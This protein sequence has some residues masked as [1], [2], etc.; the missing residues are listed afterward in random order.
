[1]RSRRT[2]GRTVAILCALALILAA[3]S[4]RKPE[5]R[6]TPS[7]SPT[8]SP[9]PTPT[10]TPTPKPTIAPS[11][12][13]TPRL[14]PKPSV[15]T[16]F[17]LSGVHI[18]LTS[19]I[20][21][22][23]HPVFI[24]HSGDGSGLLYVVQQGGRILVYDSGGRRRGTFLDIGSRI[25]CCGEQGLLGLAFHPSFRTNRRFFVT[26]TDTSGDDVLA[27][28]HATSA[29][30]AD[31][32]S[33][34]VLWR[35]SDPFPNHNGGMVAFG[36]DGYL[37]ASIGDGG[38]GGDPYN[39]GQSL[40]TMLG[41]ILRINVN[42]GSPYSSPASNPFYNRSGA[43]KEIWDYGLRNPWR[44]SFDRSTHALFIGD[45]GQNDYEEI[46]VEAA[47][48]GGRNYGWRV[49][50]GRHCY[51]ASTCNRSGKTLPIV[52]Y[53][54]AFGCSVT[55][56][57]VYRGKRYPSLN[58]AYFYGDYCSGRIW[59]MDAAA[60]LRGS[61]RV[62]QVLD[63]G[64]SISSFGEDQSGE[65]YVVNLSGTISKLRAA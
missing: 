46:D 18:R 47:G 42:A 39:N 31:A 17:S 34:K 8:A 35:V 32:G 48:R 56:G 11:K 57:Y 61:S 30:S 63:T 55:G 44:F 16:G 64:L 14:R 51:N 50:E 40:D 12:K 7:S 52:E 27:E 13:A 53:T 62:R 29:T 43:K 26:Y 15:A 54:H 25:S 58:G 6:P 19:F 1:M 38:S 41:K 20:S 4:H 9:T 59:A 37:Y 3:C 65:L 28:F 21:G 49:M 5:A 23:D 22:L 10:P 60:A 2:P 24:T 33:G 45:V 36:H